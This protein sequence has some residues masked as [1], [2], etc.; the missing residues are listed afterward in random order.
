MTKGAMTK[1]QAK[2][3]TP[4]YFSKKALKTCR[5]QGFFRKIL[6]GVIFTHNANDIRLL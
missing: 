1:I 3:T 2:I 5:F 6:R 4:Q